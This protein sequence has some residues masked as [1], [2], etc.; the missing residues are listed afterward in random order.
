MVHW[1]EEM[2]EGETE[3]ERDEEEGESRK[4]ENRW[5]VWSQLVDV[6]ILTGGF[7]NQSDFQLDP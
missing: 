1:L 5:D 2:K 7:K 4:D 6:M 3:R